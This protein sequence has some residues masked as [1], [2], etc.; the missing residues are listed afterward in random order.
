ELV[1][2]R[3]M[4]HQ[5]LVDPVELADFSGFA[6]QVMTRVEAE[7]GEKRT[8][9][10][11]EQTPAPGLLEQLVTW[12][13]PPRLAGACAVALAALFFWP[14]SPESM[15]KSTSETSVTGRTDQ[16][17]WI[18][19]GGAGGSTTTKSKRG[20]RPMETESVPT[21]RNAA[22]VESWEVAQGRVEIDQNTDD[23]STP[24][25]VWHIIDEEGAPSGDTGL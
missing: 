24:L 6:D 3:A 10:V 15:D 14:G 23:P 20:R 7:E 21:G 18:A 19:S 9:V 4:M 5:T 12:F 8:N 22:T 25:V 16:A 11:V 17:Q 1:A 2:M 13:T